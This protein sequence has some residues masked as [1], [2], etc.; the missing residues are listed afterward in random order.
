MNSTAKVLSGWLTVLVQCKCSR[1]NRQ[2]GRRERNGKE[3]ES[4]IQT[5]R[6]KARDQMAGD[7][8]GKMGE[9]LES[10]GLTR[11]SLL[12]DFSARRVFPDRQSCRRR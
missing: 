2:N 11:I 8:T 6:R 1:Q 10:S 7:E 5:E 3:D 4:K 12:N 9:R